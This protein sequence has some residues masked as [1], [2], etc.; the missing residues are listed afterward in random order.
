MLTSP[1]SVKSRIRLMNQFSSVGNFY[2][3][4]SYTQSSALTHYA[5]QA[6]ECLQVALPANLSVGPTESIF[7]FQAN[8]HF[9]G[10]SLIRKSF[11]IQLNYS[12]D[13]RSGGSFGKCMVGKIQ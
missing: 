3:Y 1:F 11:G 10:S 9:E 7:L 2:A 13:C 5:I 8:G 6:S 12:F 4:G